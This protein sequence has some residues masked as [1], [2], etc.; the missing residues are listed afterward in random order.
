MDKIRK[1]L[2]LFLTQSLAFIKKD[3]FLDISYR[4]VFYS[5]W[6]GIIISVLTIYYLSELMGHDPRRHLAV[7]AETYF[8]FVLIGLATISFLNATVN[9][10]VGVVQ[11]EQRFGTFEI[12]LSLPI[13]LRMI[14]FSF[15]LYVLGLGFLAFLFYLLM[16]YLL[17]MDF[18]YMNLGSIILVMGLG[19]LTFLSLGLMASAFVVL[20]KKGEPISWVVTSFFWLLGGAYFPITVF[21]ENLQKVSW[22]LPSTH[23]LHALRLAFLKGYSPL[24]LREEILILFIFCILFFGLGCLCINVSFYYARKKGHVVFF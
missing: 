13:T 16:G 1:D 5:R 6:I 15:S 14:L 19:I 11:G 22:F 21:P 9:G 3:F 7:Y 20:F 17:G 18:G 4:F 2:L 8:P 12:L 10:Y 24:V 23:V